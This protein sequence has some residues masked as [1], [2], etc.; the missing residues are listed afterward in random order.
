MQEITLIAEKRRLASRY[1]WNDRP[2]NTGP[3]HREL[4]SYQ[5]C[6]SCSPLGE[7]D[8]CIEN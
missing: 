2:T 1:L 3:S 4:K 8:F 7:C 5:H 6:K